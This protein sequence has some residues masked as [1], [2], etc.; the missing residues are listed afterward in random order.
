MGDGG[1]RRVVL[2]YLDGPWPGIYTFASGRLKVVDAA[3]Q[4]ERP[5]AKPK[6]APKKRAK[7]A[8]SAE[9]VYVQ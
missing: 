9:R 1:T 7:S 5:K 3:P 4:P 2:T 8:S 6:K